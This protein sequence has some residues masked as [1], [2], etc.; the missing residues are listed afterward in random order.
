MNDAPSD[1]QRLTPD[2]TIMHGPASI[3]LDSQLRSRTRRRRIVVLSLL[4]ALFTIVALAVFSAPDI[5][6]AYYLW[7]LRRRP[8]LVESWLRVAGENHIRTEALRK[9][10]LERRGAETLF[11]LYLAEYDKRQH[12]PSTIVKDL[13]RRQAIGGPDDH[14][15]LYLGETNFGCVFMQGAR[16]RQMYST[17]NLPTDVEMRRAVL[18]EM[19][20]CVGRS[21]TVERLPRYEFRIEAIIDGESKPPPWR[22][23]RLRGLKNSRAGHVCYF[24]LLEA[25]DKTSAKARE[26]AGGTRSQ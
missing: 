15:H 23:K 10:F 2:K 24:R 8:E 17:M 11:D 4:G 21:F 14:G 3:E 5:E 12:D 16:A 20:A 9:F 1:S 7:Q 6:R 26:D 25:N 13:T 18:A 19:D 22:S